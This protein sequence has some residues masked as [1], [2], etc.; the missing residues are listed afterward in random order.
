MKTKFI[1]DI[2][3]RNLFSSLYS[4]RSEIL[5]KVKSGFGYSCLTLC[6]KGFQSLARVNQVFKT[7]VIP[8]VFTRV[9]GGD[10]RL[11]FCVLVTR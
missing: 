2:K 6:W 3:F 9:E 8:F 1:T 7:K 10:R 4:L 5:E 11:D